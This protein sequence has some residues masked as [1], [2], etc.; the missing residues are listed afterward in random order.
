MS[1]SIQ[2]LTII[3]EYNDLMKNTDDFIIQLMN[4]LLNK[5][6]LEISKK[7]ELPME[8]F[9]FPKSQIPKFSQKLY[10]QIQSIKNKTTQY[11]TKSMIIENINELIKQTNPIVYKV[12]KDKQIDVYK[13]VKFDESLYF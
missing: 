4:I 6:V 11:P 9:F 5:K 7:S 3:K 2:N 1:K 8:V 12:I 10:K 13:K